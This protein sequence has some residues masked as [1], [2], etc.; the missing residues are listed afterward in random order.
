L[1][2]ARNTLLTSAVEER[3]E[4]AA[5]GAVPRVLDIPPI[6]GA[7]LLRLDFLTA[8]AGAA[9]RLRECYRAPAGRP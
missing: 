8:D 4:S 1:L 7:A 6:A 5:P 9:R 3:L 2:E